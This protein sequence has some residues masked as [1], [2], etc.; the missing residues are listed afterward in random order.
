[1]SETKC[2]HCGTTYSHER[3]AWELDATASGAAYYGSALRAAKDFPFV[4]CAERIVLDRYATGHE[5]ASDR[6]V[7]QEIAI[8]IREKGNE[9]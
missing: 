7:L 1:M 2:P 3:I 4:T 9:Q 8:R 6:M 5:Y